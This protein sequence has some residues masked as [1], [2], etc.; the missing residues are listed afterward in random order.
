MSKPKGKTRRKPGRP[1]VHGA[2]SLLASPGTQPKRREIVEYLR[3]TRENLIAD[4]SSKGE[5]GLTTGQG[6]LLNRLIAKLA[7]TRVVEEFIRRTAVMTPEGTL[8]PVLTKNY[9]QYCHSVRADLIALEAIAPGDVRKDEIL[10]PFQL[11]QRIDRKN[12]KKGKKEKSLTS[13]KPF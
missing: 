9:L 4:L 8:K 3:V 13:S 5:A 12:A 2:F 1:P 11:A 6:I 7:V 10:T